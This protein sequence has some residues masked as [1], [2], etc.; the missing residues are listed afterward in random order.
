MEKEPTPYM[1]GIA[2]GEAG[3]SGPPF[4]TPDSSWSER[5]Y[6]AGW[7]RGACKRIDHALDTV[8]SRDASAKE[9]T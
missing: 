2:D 1:R 5:L 9:K 8:S 7:M 3:K 6:N 4:P